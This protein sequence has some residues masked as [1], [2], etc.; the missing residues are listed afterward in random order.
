VTVIGEP[1]FEFG[2][3]AVPPTQPAALRELAAAAAA[4]ATLGYDRFWVPDQEF[5]ADP[6]VL[7]GD[8]AARTDVSFGLGLA[9]TNPFSRHPVQIA[10]SMAS[11]VHL[12]QQA[13]TCGAAARRWVLGLGMGNPN[14]VLNPLGLGGSAT[15]RRL[16]SAVSLVRE[17]L[18]GRAVE[19]PWDGFVHAPVSLGIEAARCEIYLGTRG[20]KTLRAG[21]R[22]ADGILAEALF[23][24]DLV[25]WT[26][27]QA[28]LPPGSPHICWQT[29]ILLEPGQPLPESARR[30]TAMLVRTTTPAVLEMLG[31]SERARTRAR[32][33]RLALE[34]VSDSDV[35][36]FVV[37]GSPNEIT[38]TVLRAREAGATGW[39]SIF[40]GD[41]RRI[42]DSMRAFSDGVIRP[43]RQSGQHRSSRP[44]Q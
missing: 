39:T 31:I 18:A 15:T 23:R 26:R 8:I 11:L 29:V 44:P 35:R 20:P 38:Q 7:L 16:V 1:T 34:D 37:C 9:L 43:V 10:R 21:A 17:L 28:M 40:L 14:L 32:D 24:P 41:P 30:F 2:C 27:E 13:S 4:A 33:G 12:D 6:F 3:T 25:R 19:P 42:L 22:A 5:Y 36:C